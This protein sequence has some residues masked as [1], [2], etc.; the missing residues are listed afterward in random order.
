MSTWYNIKLKISNLLYRNVFYRLGYGRP[1]KSSDWEN[2]YA[3]GYWDHLES[4]NEQERYEMISKLVQD[5]KTSPSILDVGCG[6]GILYRHLKQNVPAFSYLGLDISGNAISYAQKEFPEATFRQLDFDKENLD[7]KFD[8][9]IFNE[10]LEYFI[11]PL[12]KL[13]RCNSINLLPDG[14]FIISMFKGHD[15]IWN[16]ITPH[17]EILKEVDVRNEQGQRWKIKM[18]KPKG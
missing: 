1:E 12:D 3:G 18:I 16:T 5:V 7:Q 17:F 15:G 10:T 14:R 9:I 11:R 4:K 13:N 2:G 6:K 8:I